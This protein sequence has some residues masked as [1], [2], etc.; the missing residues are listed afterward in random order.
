M[1][2]LILVILVLGLCMGCS[3]IF[4][5][6]VV[7]S[8]YIAD[9]SLEENFY[10]VRTCVGLENFLS[11]GDY[12]C[13]QCLDDKVAC[14]YIP[15]SKRE[16]MVWAQTLKAELEEKLKTWKSCKYK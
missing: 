12:Y 7:I 6:K 15:R 10:T 5:P 11:I 3:K 4:P 8:Q 2:K 16:Q 14:D 13:E 9:F 1:K